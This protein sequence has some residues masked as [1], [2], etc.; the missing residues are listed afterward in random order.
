[1]L[2][3]CAGKLARTVLR[4]RSCGNVAL[5][6]DHLMDPGH[7]ALSVR[8]PCELLGV[9]RSGLYY[10]CKPPP[11]EDVDALN[12]IRDI[13]MRRS[14]YG[15]RRITRELQSAGF[16][17]NRKRVQRLMALAGIQAIYPGSNTSK[18][19]KAQSSLASGYHLLA[20]GQGLDVS[21]GP[22]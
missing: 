14:F 21:G 18:R 11:V 1:M 9:N 5:L 7:D 2:E 13:W 22:D 6:P 16:E 10:E 12:R 3:P 19:N 15:Y 8:R 4:G 20:Y 17:V